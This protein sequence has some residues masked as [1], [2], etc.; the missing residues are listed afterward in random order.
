MNSEVLMQIGDCGSTNACSCMCRDLHRSR[1]F[2]F[3][4]EVVCHQEFPHV[5]E[6]H[7]MMKNTVKPITGSLWPMS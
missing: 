1:A 7:G 3:D 6:H 4:S 2:L 5:Q